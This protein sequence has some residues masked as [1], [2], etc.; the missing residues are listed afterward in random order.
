MI[1]PV[2]VI[3]NTGNTTLTTLDIEY[4][5]EGGQVL[6]Y[7]W[8]GSL[9]FLEKANQWIS[10]SVQANEPFFIYYPMALTH[11]PY[12]STPTTSPSQEEKF[13]HSPARFK[14]N[15]QDEVARRIHGHFPNTV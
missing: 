2:V 13:K 1:Y 8:N 6:N 15:T 14:E 3:Q 9:E 5:V 10:D 4:F 12:Y 11:S 7:T